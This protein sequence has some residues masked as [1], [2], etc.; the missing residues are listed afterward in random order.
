MCTEFENVT[1]CDSV[2]LP[3]YC[4]VGA[5]ERGVYKVSIVTCISSTRQRLVKHVTERYAVNED[6]RPLLDNEF[7]YHG[8]KHVS[9]TTHTQT[10]EAE[11]FK[12]VISTRFAECYK[13]RPEDGELDSYET[14]LHSWPPLWSSG[15]SFW[16]QIQTSLV[17]FPA[18]PH[19]FRSRGYGTGVHSASWRQLRSYLNEKVA[20]PV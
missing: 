6:K 11:P 7:S 15:Q 12:G 13:R 18:L 8:K 5:Q 17:R 4:P 19:F 10:T 14:G 16:L 2:A 20:A 1:G 9:G 3:W